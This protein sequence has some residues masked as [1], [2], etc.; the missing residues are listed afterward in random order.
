MDS[1]VQELDNKILQYKF[2]GRLTDVAC[3]NKIKMDYYLMLTIAAAWDLKHLSMDEAAIKT[4][5]SCLQ[6]PETGKLIRLIETGFSLDKRIVEIF[7]LYKQGRNLRFGHTTFD[8]VEA[9]K[10]NEVCEQCWKSLMQLPVLADDNSEIIRKLYQENNDL[11]FVSR[12]NQSGDMLLKPFG[13]KKNIVQIPMINYKAYLINKKNSIVEGDLFVFVDG[14]YVKL[15][16]FIKYNQKEEL[17][18]MLMDIERPLAFKMAYIYRTQYASDSE[19]YLDEFPEELRCYFPEDKKSIGKNGIGLNRFSQY[20]LFTQEYYKNVHIE[21]QEKLDSFI[22]GNMS[23]GAVRGVGG[24]GKTSAVFMWMNRILNNEE[25]ILDRI[26]QK[27]KISRIIFLSA[28]SKTY[29]RKIDAESLSNIWD[30]ESDVSTYNDIVEA[31]YA[32]FHSEESNSIT[33]DEKEEYLKNYANRSNAALIVI[34]DYESLPIEDRAKIQLLKDSLN[35]KAIKMLI[36]TRFTSKE[37]KDIIVE[38]LNTGD[39]S[40]MTDYIF[41]TD[42]WRQELTEEEMHSLTGGLPLLIWYAKACYNMNQLSSKRLKARFTGPDEGLE[43]YLFDNF[44]QCFEDNFAKNFIMFATRYYELHKVLRISRIIAVFLCIDVPQDYKKEDEEFYFRELED[45]KLIAINKTTDLIDF[46]PL[47]VYMD[48]YTKKIDPATSCQE[49]LLR[50]ITNLDEEKY[51]GLMAVINSS[52]YLEDDT[53]IRI[54]KR[55]VDFSHND[56]QIRNYSLCKLFKLCD[57]KLTIYMENEHSFQNDYMLII[58]MEE[59]IIASDDIIN[60]RYEMVR[61]FLKSISVS[62]A[63]QREQVDKIACYGNE[64]IRKAMAEA[65][66]ARYNDELT[67]QELENR[68]RFLCSLIPGFMSKIEDLDCK[69]RNTSEI[70][71]AL[72]EISIFCDVIKE[73]IEMLY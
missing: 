38:R 24:V 31:F 12:I 58:A 55:I 59:F 19:V 11:Y 60:E 67:N 49:D 10:L 8:E 46:S 27:F 64:I 5:M 21:V 73:Q 44:V 71:E 39:C 51:N 30:I 61:D 35:P 54:L 2:D 72:D 63:S 25:G 6:R 26:R 14:G 17:F 65:L 62:I 18:M 40:N 28:K 15:S 68:T 7:D 13:E 3:F 45:L 48:K 56:E 36:T 52:E 53:R 4:V 33:L 70:T 37:S 34:D 32:V 1:I 23:Y 29:S 9:Q 41:G 43:N 20:D 42:N 22:S 16:P 66:K 69:N 57:D 50:I 47:M